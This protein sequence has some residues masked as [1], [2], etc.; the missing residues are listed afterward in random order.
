MTMLVLEFGMMVLE[1]D[2]Q[3]VASTMNNDC[4]TD[5]DRDYLRY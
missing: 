4:D 2:T 3:R 5:R 1:Y